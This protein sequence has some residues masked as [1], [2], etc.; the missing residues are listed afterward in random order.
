MHVL[1][2]RLCFRLLVGLTIV[3]PGLPLLPAVRADADRP[4]AVLAN[5]NRRPAGQLTGGVLTLELRAGVGLWRPGGEGGHVRRVEA[6]GEFTSD[7]STPAPLIRVPE[8]T[9]IDAAVRNDLTRPLRVHGLCARGG[10]ACAPVDVGVGETRRVRF[11]S[12]PAGTYHYWATTTGM[13]L[14]FRASVDTQLSGAFIVDPAGTTSPQD[15]VLVITEWTS[16]TPE[17]LQAIAAAVDPGVAFMKMRPDVGFTI[18]GRAWPETERLAYTT[19]ERV[20]WRVLNL[21]TQVHPMH[22]HGF[23]FDVE[24]LGDGLRARPS[25][26]TPPRVVTQLMA[27]GATM[28]MTWI[29]ERAGNWL[30]HCHVLGHISPSIHVDGS[31]K[32]IDPHAAHGASAGMTGMVMGVTVGDGPRLRAQGDGPPRVE[33]SRDRAGK[34][35]ETASLEFSTR[36][37]PSPARGPSPRQLSLHMRSDPRRFGE[38]P[39]YGFVLSEGAARPATKAPVEAP[40]PTLVLTRDEPVEISLVNQLPEGTAIHWHGME[41]DSYYDGVHGFGGSGGQVTPMIGPGE[42]FVVK[43]T[44]PRAGTFIYH[45]HL[46]DDRQL[47]SGLYGALIVVDPNEDVRSRD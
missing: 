9:E 14:A 39:A 29:P 22:L 7:L 18:N 16:L 24:A 32:P 46:H 15:R 11:A 47:G 45:T 2:S 3:A 20:R 23:Y 28:E 6:F 19:G 33:N 44:P 40:G 17:Q 43:F 30:F 41:L 1:A 31:P 5:D 38:A 35:P 8:G 10:P 21:S 37:G 25:A 4:P 12:G 34:D 26:G 36:G 13:P 27:P 42:T